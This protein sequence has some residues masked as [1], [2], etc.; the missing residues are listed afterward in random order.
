MKLNVVTILFFTLLLSTGLSTKSNAQHCGWH[1]YGYWAP[2]HGSDTSHCGHGYWGRH[3]WGGC[4]ATASHHS[5]CPAMAERFKEDSAFLAKFHEGHMMHKCSA[6][7]AHTCSH[8]DC[9]G[10]CHHGD[11]YGWRWGWGNP[12]RYNRYYYR[13]AGY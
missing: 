6:D 3:A 4:H 13:G 12:W 1:R 5:C 8:S 7:K 9:K 10:N 2:E 11:Y